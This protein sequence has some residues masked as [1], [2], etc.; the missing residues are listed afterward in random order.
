MQR[1]YLRSSTD[2]AIKNNVESTVEVRTI[3]RYSVF[4]LFY[5]QENA[6]VLT[7]GK[8]TRAGRKNHR[9]LCENRKRQ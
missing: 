5:T 8:K 7:Q 9:I 6:A 3:Y 1:K 4:I 2:S